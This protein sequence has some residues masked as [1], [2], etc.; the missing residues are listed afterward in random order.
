MKT[1]TTIIIALIVMSIDANAQIPNSNFEDWE[2]DING[3]LNPLLWETTNDAPSVSVEQ[4]SP[5]CSGDISMLVKPFDAG[6]FILA[7][8]SYTDFAF[9]LRPTQITACIKA[10]VMPGDVVLVMFSSHRGDSD[11]EQ[12]SIVAAG[13]SCTFK[14]F[15]STNQFECFTMPL[16]YLSSE[17]PDS[18]TIMIIAGDFGNAQIG[19]EIIIDEI[20]FTCET[21]IN[22]TVIPESAIVGKN[23]PNPAGR[24]TSIPLKL[25]KGSTV[26]LHLFDVLGKEVKTISYGFL[27]AGENTLTLLVND[28]AAGIYQCKIVGDNFTVTTKIAVN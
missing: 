5:A 26:T 9:N 20:S 3:N 11:I 6:G 17:L 19:T 14:I 24:S 23:Y 16:S 21:G 2:T 4:Y 28:L 8:I 7:G 13:D 10:T 18:A 25:N 12:D 15:T 22:E 27:N 1:L